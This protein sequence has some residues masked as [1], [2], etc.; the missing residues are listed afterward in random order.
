MRSRIIIYHRNLIN[1]DKKGLTDPYA[2]IILLP[3]AKKETKKETKVIKDNLNPIWNHEFEWTVT[4]AEAKS[5]TIKVSFFDEKGFFEKQP[6][7][8]LGEV[9]AF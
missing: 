3:D 1:T 2:Q 6:T 7:T 8:F 9:T 4:Y 5:K